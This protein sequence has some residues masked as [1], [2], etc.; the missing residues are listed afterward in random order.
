M[1][2][3]PQQSIGLA[4]LIQQVKQELLSTVP[5]RSADAPILFVD[6]V[7]LELKVTVSRE[8]KGGVKI[9]VV[10]IGGGELGGVIKREDVHTVKVTLSP[11]FDKERL[12]EFY[13]TL[14]SDK[15]P[16]TVKQSLEALLKGEEGNLADQF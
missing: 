11:L 4:E 5:G 8:G 13:Q 10:S 12:M 3:Q 6:A 14:H 9:D 2:E 7:E 1:P 16:T 15:V